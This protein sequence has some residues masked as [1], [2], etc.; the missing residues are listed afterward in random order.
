MEKKNCLLGIFL[1]IISST[2]NLNAAN[3]A[4][5]NIYLAA[6]L[7]YSHLGDLSNNT[8]TR[9][10]PASDGGGTQSVKYAYK[11]DPGFNGGLA[12][13]KHFMSI[14]MRLE[15]DIHHTRGQA[16]DLIF[17]YSLKG[18]TRTQDIDLN[19]TTNKSQ[20][21]LCSTFFGGNVYY[22]FTKLVSSSLVPF[23]GI[24]VGVANIRLKEKKTVVDINGN[25]TTL[26]SDKVATV[27][28]NEVSFQLMVG[29]QYYFSKILSLIAEYRYF[30][31][32]PY[33]YNTDYSSNIN[34][35]A[36]IFKD[37]LQTHSVNVGIKAIIA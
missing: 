4:G 16:K 10:L 5:N 1:L 34:K 23:L 32:T 20:G 2:G 26:I 33:S 29:T 35:T 12:I 18:N 25:S 11:F 24:G 3:A 6:K 14:N 36:S 8:Q 31:S 30:I 21:D 19:T 7:G 28:E 22:D 27:S 9:S 15:L 13:G 37:N 17:N